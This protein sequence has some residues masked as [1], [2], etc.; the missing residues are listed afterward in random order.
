MTSEAPERIWAQD[1]D[2]K[3]CDYIGGGWWDDALD[4]TQCPHTIEYIR[5]DHAL[6]ARKAR[7]KKIREDALRE[8]ADLVRVSR[9][10]EFDHAG[11]AVGYRNSSPNEVAEA[12]LALISGDKTDG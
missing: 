10:F 11:N 1:A 7:D 3:E 12:I 4:G 9:E 6:A 5:A 2:P 8:A